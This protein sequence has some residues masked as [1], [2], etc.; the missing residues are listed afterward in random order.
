MMDDA[1]YKEDIETLSSKKY[2]WHIL[3][4]NRILVTGA[5]GMIGSII[6]DTLVSVISKGYDFSITA[7]SRDMDRLNNSF[8]RYENHKLKLIPHDVNDPIEGEYDIIFHCASNTHPLQYSNDPIGTIT[9]NVIGL[10]NLLKVKS[11]DKGRFVFLSSVEIYGNNRGDTESFDE[12]YCGYIDCNT[13]RAG[14]NESKRLGES[15]CQ[16]YAKQQGIDFVIP[17]LS[18]SFGPSLK[19]D[20]TKALSQFLFK[21]A[22]GE[23]I[24]LKSDGLQ[25]Y[26]YIYSADAA[27]GVFFTLFYG[28]NKEAYN[29][30]GFDGTLREIAGTICQMSGVGLEFDTPE[31]SEKEG[32]STATVAT[33][34]IDKIC[35]KGWKPT[36]NLKESL[37]R[38]LTSMKETI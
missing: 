15:L 3:N 1:I 2:P 19:R 27:D 35:R 31:K 23:N 37:Q 13:V 22:K 33:L 24:V 20:D 4:G 7:M 14:Y 38:T 5:T 36:Y 12:T 8:G 25:R 10:N 34:D 30:A 11:K 32:Y 29:I 16:A 9:T 26:S 6:V 18:R 21:A 17:R 28:N